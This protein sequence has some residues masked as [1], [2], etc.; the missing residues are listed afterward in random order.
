MVQLQSPGVE[1]DDRGAVLVTGSNKGIGYQIATQLLREHRE[2]IAGC[3]TQKK[4]DDTVAR[5]RGAAPEAAEVSG[6][7]VNVADSDSVASAVRY[8]R[9]NFDQRLGCVVNNAGVNTMS[10][11]QR[12]WN[13]EY[14]TNFLGPIGLAIAL[15]PHLKTGGHIVNVSSSL[16]QLDAEGSE[17]GGLPPS[18]AY[19]TAIRGAA[20]LPDL[21]RIPFDI[22]DRKCMEDAQSG[23][24]P[25]PLYKLTKAMLNKATALLAAEETLRCRGITACAVCPGSCLSDMNPMG[26]DDAS[27]G[28]AAVVWAVNH[29]NPN[30]LNGKLWMRGCEIPT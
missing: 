22:S 14:A 30:E 4:V 29:T 19:K 21:Q 2:V 8:I 10:W 18:D 13:K 25:C 20:T 12:A 1:R 6:L 23:R 5:L 27:T 7:V 9:E 16:G 17:W 11:S 28:A 24:Y 3:R 15:V 26:R